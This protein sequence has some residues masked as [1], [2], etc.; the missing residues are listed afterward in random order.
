VHPKYKTPY[1]GTLITGA[2][3]ATIAGLLPVTILG[4]LV[5]IGTLL[6]F[7][8]V[9]IG[10]LVLR[11]TRPDVDRPF[12]VPAPWFTCCRRRM[13]CSGMMVSLPRDTWWRLL[14]WTVIGMAIYA[15]YGYRNSALRTRPLT[16]ATATAG[17][18]PVERGR[19]PAR[20][21]HSSSDLRSLT[22]AAM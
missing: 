15:F 3:A 1:V 2:V 18:P 22:G 16:P 7:T 10:V 21:R 17:R 9:C 6:A 8:V 19:A 14:I 4:E 5:S 13:I 12:R 11:Y 20:H